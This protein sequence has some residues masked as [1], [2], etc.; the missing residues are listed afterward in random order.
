MEFIDC[1]TFDGQPLRTFVEV[2]RYRAE[3][4]PQRIAFEFI[5]NSTRNEFETC[6]YVELDR[7]ARGLAGKLQQLG[8]PGERALLVYAQGLDY[9]AAFFGCL[10][11]GVIAVPVYPPRAN[12]S[13]ERVVG[14]AKDSQA[15]VALTTERIGRNGVHVSAGPMSDV[16]WICSDLPESYAPEAW[17]DSQVDPQ[18]VAFLQYTSGSTSNPKGV[19][20]THANLMHNSAWTQRCFETSSE[21][22]YVGWLPPYH[23]MGL[24]GGMLQPVYAGFP[25]TL[26]PPAAFLQR[27]LRWLELVSSRKATISGGPNSAFDLCVRNVQPERRDALDLSAWKVAFCG[28]E[29]IRAETLDR[30]AACFAPCGFRREAFYPCYGLAEATLFASGGV[31]GA[32]P[33][34]VSFDRAALLKGGVLERPG[35]AGEVL[36]G[37]GAVLPNETRVVDPATCRPCA[38]GIVGEIWL[39]GPSIAQGYWNRP[40]ETAETFQARLDGEPAEAFLRTGDMGFLHDG[41]LF[42]AGRLKEVIIVRGRKYFPPDIEA[43]V[44]QCHD[45][46]RYGTSAA[47]SVEES[48][49]ERLVIV[50][51]LA[52]TARK[53][54]HLALMQAIRSAIADLNGIEVAAVVLTES[55]GIPKTSSG[56]IQRLSCRAAYLSGKLAVAAQWRAAAPGQ[57][58]TRGSPAAPAS[59]E[60]SRASRNQIRSWLIA[61]LSRVTGLDPRE[62]H[63]SRPFQ[64]FGLDSVKSV[65]LSGEL[66]Q[67]LGRELAPT[68]VWEYPTIDALAEGLAGPETP[69]ARVTPRHAA[70]EPIAVIGIGCR[71]PGAD[72]PAAFWQALREGADAIGPLPA[73]RRQWAEWPTGDQ[74]GYL[75]NIDL[76]DAAHFEIAPREAVWMDPQQ[77]LL[78][79]VSW[80]ALEHAGQPISSLVGMAAG[81]FVGISNVDYR[82][83]QPLIDA[84]SG[85]GNAA[86][87]AANR[88]SY[89]LG[90]QGPSLA[91]DTACSS[92]LVAVHL[93]CR[94][95]RTGECELALAGGVNLILTP[96]LTVAFSN[97]KML[98]PDGRCKTFD[99]SAD[100]YV[101]GE[102]CGVV[103]LKRL[104]DA[105]RDSDRILAVIRGSAVN[106]DGRSNGLTAPNANAQEAVIRAALADAGLEPGAVSYV[107]AHGTGTPLGDPIEIRSM[108]RVYCPDRKKAESLVVG[109]VKTNIGHLEAAAGVAGLIKLVLALQHGEIPPHLHFRQANPHLG[110]ESLPVRVAVELERWSGPRVGA[111]TGLGFGGTNAHIVVEAAP[112]EQIEREKVGRPLQLVT[113]S[114]RSAQALE[115]LAGRYAEQL[116]GGGAL[117]ED[118]AYT[119]NTRRSHFPWRGYA[120]GGNASE[121]AEKLRTVR[122]EGP[123]SDAPAVAF[124]FSG[125]GSQYAGMGR[126][127]Y[128]TEGVFR[129]VVDRCEAVLQDE[130]GEGIVEVLY[131]SKGERI[132]R[133]GYTQPALYAVET[134]LAALWRSWGVEP[135][136]VMGH[137]VGEYAAAH[138]AGVF[139]L[140]DGL[141]L[142]AER[143]RLMEG[144]RHAGGMA[145]VLADE[146]AVRGAVERSLGKVSV[147]AVNGPAET[148]LAGD[149]RALSKAVAELEAAGLRCRRLVVSHGFHSGQM[150]PMLEAYAE[151]AGRVA[152]AR[153]RTL[154]VGNV[155]GD[156]VGEEGSRPEYWVRHVREPVWF[157]EGMKSLEREGCR[158]YLEV[159]PQGKLLALGRQ[160]VEEEGRWWVASLRRGADDSRQMLEGLGAL[161]GAGVP[162]N[163]ANVAG[164]RKRPV[165]LPTY[166]F[167]RQR[168]WLDEALP[169]PPAAVESARE[170]TSRADAVF[171]EEL[172]A[173]P[174]SERLERLTKR[175]QA[176]T[177]RTLQLGQLADPHQGFFEMGM[178][179]LTAVELKTRLEQVLHRKLPS[180]IAFDYPNI[181]R[182]TRYL[183]DLIEGEPGPSRQTIA[184]EQRMADEPIAIIGA[185][186]RFPHGSDN[187]EAFWQMLRDGVDAIGPIPL[188]RWDGNAYYDPDS[189]SPGKSYVREGGFLEA[190]IDEFD[191]RFFGIAPREASGMDPQQRLLMEVCWEALE[192]AGAATPALSGSRTGVFV[193]IN[194]NDFARRMR[195]GGESTLDAY[196]FTGNTFSV[197]AGRVSHWL[198]LHGP[199]LAV[200]TACSSSLVSVHLACRS[201]QTMEC[202]MALAGGVNLMLSPDANVVLSRMR[203]LAPD[204]RCKTFDAAADG[205]ARG[206]GAG[207]VVLKRLSKAKTDGDRIL[208]VIRGTAVNHDGPSSGLTVPNGPAQEMLIRQALAN[209]CISPEKVGYLETHGTGTALGDP[210]E[211]QAVGNTLCAGRDTAT[212]LMIGSVKTNIG[213]L[214]AAAGVAGLIKAALVLHHGEVPPHLH[215]TTPSPRIAWD[216]LNLTIPSRT[217]PWTRNGSPRIAAVSS[218]GMSGT[219]AFAVL[220]EA[221]AEAERAASPER[222][223]HILTLSARSETALDQLVRRYQGY[224]ADRPDQPFADVAFTANAGRSHFRHRLFLTAA[225]S[226]EAS[227]KLSAGAPRR[228]AP[229]SR[230]K[231]G[232]LFT[233]QGSQ[234]A[235]MG[236]SLYETQPIFRSVMDRAAE[237]L[238]PLL[239]HP[240]LAVL[241]G[242]EGARIDE[243]V[244]TQPALF[245]VEYGLA[246]LWRCWGIEPAVVMGHSVGEYVAAC[247][248]GV[249]GFEDGLRLVA[250][251]ARR[252]QELPAGGR[253]AAVFAP[254]ERVADAVNGY[255]DRVSIA[256]V[257]GPG[258]TVIS[259]DGAAVGSV[260][261]VL[262]RTGVRTQGLTVSHAFHSPLMEPMLEGFGKFAA[263]LKYAKPRIRLISNVS[264][265]AL[266]SADGAYWAKHVREAVQFQRCMETMAA[267]ECTVLVEIGPGATLLGLGRQCVEAETKQWLPSLRHGR[268]DWESLLESLGQLYLEGC[269]VDWAAFDRPYGRRRLSLPTYPFQRERHWHEA[270]G[271]ITGTAN[272]VHELVWEESDPPSTGA[273]PARGTYVIFDDREG[274]GAALAAR[275]GAPCVMVEPATAY[276]ES[277]GRFR[278]DP[279]NPQHFEKMFRAVGACSGIVH[280]WSL[281]ASE[282]EADQLV[283]CGSVVHLVHGALRSG[284]RQ[285]PKT[286][287]VTRGAQPAGGDSTLTSPAQATLWGLGRV[288]ALEHPELWGGLIDLDQSDFESLAD[289]V[290]AA[291]ADPDGE[292]QI[293]FRSGKRYV[294][295]IVQS[296]TPAF[297]RVP[298][299]IRSDATYLVTGGAGSLGRNVAAWLVRNGAT[300][301]V[302]TG[303]RRP[304][305][306]ALA[307][308]TEMER[309]GAQVTFVPADVSHYEELAVALGAIHPDFPL[310][311]V[312]HTAGVLDD[313]VLMNLDWGRFAS[314]MA[315]KVAG[316]WNLHAATQNLDLDFFVLFSSAAALLG[317][318]GQSN[319]AAA[320]A[321][322]D[323]LAHYRRARGLSAVSIN[324]GP[325]AEVGMAASLSQRSSR[326]WTPRG[327]TALSIEDGLR[328]LASV[329]RGGA[330]SQLC[331][332]PVNWTEFLQQFPPDTR[333]PVLAR[334]ARA[335]Q[336]V[337]PT[338]APASEPSLLRQFERAMPGERAGVLLAGI[339]SEVAHV[340]GAGGVESIDPQQG[341]FDM[342]LDSLMAVELKT[343]LSSALKRNLPASLMFQYPNIE[344]LAGHLLRELAPAEN[345]HAAVLKP[346][347]AMD[348]LEETSE[349]DLLLLLA[350]EVDD[351]ASPLAGE[352][353]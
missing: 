28:S 88:I 129:E 319:Y 243:T 292:D 175:M 84:Y 95:L 294:A 82:K 199:S 227:A 123:I 342:G 159:G 181:T 204:G 148:V 79:E 120:V 69:A 200:D 295:R 111:V 259:G 277:R 132:D 180:T 38:P 352:S 6:T 104:S 325:W 225:N 213:H 99:A 210:I 73:V 64:S 131:G 33:R 265:E 1:R 336:A 5:T 198:G 113:V 228:V 192:N 317:S 29:P 160:C 72:G 291:I 151:V 246:E 4:Q 43:T 272:W 17:R 223:L 194:T 11:A 193:G 298:P 242:D 157:W 32:R 141:R 188:G 205:Y 212:P 135:A 174:L 102:G 169:E 237:V 139:G 40:R 220:E 346:E 203:A 149:D 315:P 14:I 279:G 305:A 189:E 348:G 36:V 164:E 233:G 122:A 185:G 110:L 288:L 172:L 321:Y 124:L 166:P 351:A 178:D 47:F 173:A 255:G 24:I 343:R 12:Q 244:Y 201:L 80:E 316:S 133:T 105:R 41:E 281:S 245:A 25:A 125:Q 130:R 10:Y 155:S 137:S 92:S 284:M 222:P 251:R 261:E 86:S 344:A 30:F 58:A 61:H 186:C 270:A 45:A 330:S 83:L 179:S 191:A 303:R 19:I 264:G 289:Q 97:A 89:V 248:A 338:D 3:H 230:P 168:Y 211:I 304:S 247:V 310:R 231:V 75:K 21:S 117:L 140:E 283:G 300:R 312:I 16:K 66:E 216:G 70:D 15:A 293:A 260:I 35:S 44:A 136:A 56:K 334:I 81:V 76:F 301:L 323:A 85:T 171:V 152:Y 273:C 100:G 309:G 50:H 287:L 121:V 241:Y 332:M 271:D 9:I 324:W 196:V 48:G 109:S 326:K 347:T 34:I 78:L 341:F 350:G 142:V 267:Q 311:G 127:L 353:G 23:D 161:Y 31:Q 290:S 249:F 108:A 218:F 62:I 206:E 258:S 266:Q 268:E 7:R 98:A 339:Q 87:I 18:S 187:P 202:D 90:C 217:L 329:H 302:L 240:L 297:S 307:A 340:M 103:V 256:A 209:A 39:S 147:A 128:E 138:V 238:H 208:A 118:L 345:G 190:A 252:M 37:S 54:D 162:V 236:R 13:L 59:R 299:Q 116:E 49:E 280:M 269:A 153:P 71:F 134:A 8:L 65:A 349:Q 91:V 60:G 224:L 296:T 46:L 163:W 320:N 158:A 150:D 313:G 156:V 77:R 232:F 253:M 144:L 278:I 229:N 176:E 327:V 53:A 184:S 55:L 226:S 114:A 286:W 239:E 20:I 26:L 285:F 170:Q 22:R 331:V 51:E 250:E 183:L 276:S 143:G 306:E 112:E 215:F 57:V 154:L 333:A 219:N 221:P 126:N 177:A 207:V 274:F 308:I 257:N 328:V 93:A 235:G 322:M 96:E 262:E 337:R 94:S 167:Q 197:A 67:W 318:P 282:G 195:A 275:L 254:M 165:A 119:A 214:E 182:L 63:T 42:V 68:L 335:G 314:V 52:R 107:E 106:Q 101:R 27:P 146:S 2:V 263:G 115:Q 74:G 234:Y 145:A